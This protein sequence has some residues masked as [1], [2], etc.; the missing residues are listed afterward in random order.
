MSV[1]DKPDRS[2]TTKPADATDLAFRLAMELD[3]LSDRVRSAG[4]N[5]GP[6]VNWEPAYQRARALLDEFWGGPQ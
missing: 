3:S 2:D 5:G 6:I 4:M 1:N